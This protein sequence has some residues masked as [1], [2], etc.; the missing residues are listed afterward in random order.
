MYGFC[1]G[2]YRFKL[3]FLLKKVELCTRVHKKMLLLLLFKD[4]RMQI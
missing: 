2:K 4:M 1:E 3:T